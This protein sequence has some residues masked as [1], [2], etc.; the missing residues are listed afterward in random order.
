MS[1]EN[2]SNIEYHIYIVMTSD[3]CRMQEL[4]AIAQMYVQCN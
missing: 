1:M 2:T 3:G 4:V